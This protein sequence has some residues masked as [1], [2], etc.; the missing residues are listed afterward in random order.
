MSETAPAAVP[1]PTLSVAERVVAIVS[2]TLHLDL[3][4]PD[5]QDRIGRDLRADSLD[6][7]EIAMTIDDEFDLRLSNDMDGNGLY[8]PDL[9]VARLIEIVEQALQSR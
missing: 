7:S 6:Q 8:D 5:L 2:E 1:E 9:T 4:L 3:P